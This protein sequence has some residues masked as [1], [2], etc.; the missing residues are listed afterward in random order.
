MKIG[1]TSLHKE[2]IVYKFVAQSFLQAYIN[3]WKMWLDGTPQYLVIE[4]INRGNCAQIFG[5][6]FQLLDRNDAGYSDYPIT[7]D[8]DM[9]SNLMKLL[10]KLNC[11]MR[12]YLR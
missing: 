5:D 1:G 12:K 11:L 6:L 3:A 2:Q 8:K 9:Q 4:E 10:K 7:A